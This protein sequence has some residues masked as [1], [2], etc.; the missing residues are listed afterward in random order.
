RYFA[1]CELYGKLLDQVKDVTDRMKESTFEYQDDEHDMDRML[2]GDDSPSIDRS[3][4]GNVAA[5]DD[6]KK[7]GLN[8]ILKKVTDDL[9]KINFDSMTS[10]LKKWVQ[11]S[12]AS[13]TLLRRLLEETGDA[14]KETANLLSLHKFI[15]DEYLSIH[16][17]EAARA[18]ADFHENIDQRL[19]WVCENCG[20]DDSLALMTAND[21]MKDLQKKDVFADVEDDALAA[22]NPDLNKQQKILLA[23]RVTSNRTHK[24]TMIQLH[25]VQEEH[26]RKITLNRSLYDHMMLTALNEGATR[27]EPPKLRNLEQRRRAS[28]HAP[29][30]TLVVCAT[31]FFDEPK[32]EA[33]SEEAEGDS[34]EESGTRPKIKIPER[35]V[36]N[37]QLQPGP[38]TPNQQSR[39]VDLTAARL[40]STA[41]IHFGDIAGL[42]AERNS[43]LDLAMKLVKKSSVPEAVTTPAAASLTEGGKYTKQIRMLRSMTST[44]RATKTPGDSVEYQWLRVKRERLWSD[45]NNVVVEVSIEDIMKDEPPD[46]PLWDTFQFKKVSLKELDSSKLQIQGSASGYGNPL[47]PSGSARPPL[48]PA[49][50]AT[51]VSI[52]F[53][54]VRELPVSLSSGATE[55]CPCWKPFERQVL[56]FQRRMIIDIQPF[57]HSF[58]GKG[59]LDLVS[60]R[61]A[62]AGGSEPPGPA[63]AVSVSVSVS[64]QP[65]GAVLPPAITASAHAALPADSKTKTA[66]ALEEFPKA[67]ASAGVTCSPEAT[68]ADLAQLLLSTGHSAAAVI[69]EGEFKRSISEQDI[70][71]GYLKGTPWDLK[72]GEWLRGLGPEETAVDTGGWRRGQL[73]A[74][75]RLGLPADPVKNFL[76]KEGQE[77]G[78]FAGDATVSQIMEPVNS[79]PVC[80]HCCTVQELLQALLR[81]PGSPAGAALET[82]GRRLLGLCRAADVLWAFC[83]HVDL[84]EKMWKRL[85]V[86]CDL[87]GL[88]C[89]AMAADT[90]LRSAALAMGHASEARAVSD[91]FLPHLLAYQPGGKALVGVLSPQQL[92][93]SSW[94]GTGRSPS[95]LEPHQLEAP[96]AW[97][98]H[99]PTTVGD[100]VAQRQT[101]FCFANESLGEACDDLAK[102]GRTAAIVLGATSG[103]MRGVLTENDILQAFVNG[104]S[105]DRIIDSWLRGDDARLPGFVDRCHFRL[106]SA[107]DIALGLTTSDSAELGGPP[108]VSQAMK[109]RRFV[110]TCTAEDSLADAF[111]ALADSRQNCALVAGAEDFG[112]GEGGEHLLKGPAGVAICGV[113]TVADIVRAV[114]MHK[115]GKCSHT[116]LGCWRLG[117]GMSSCGR[118]IA[119]ESSLAAAAL[120]MAQHGVHHLL[121]V[122]GLSGEVQQQ[123]QQVLG[124]ISALDIVVAMDKWLSERSHLIQ[125]TLALESVVG[126]V[127]TLRRK[128]IVLG[129]PV[130][131][132]FETRPH[133]DTGIRVLRH[134]MVPL[135]D[136]VSQRLDFC[137]VEQLRNGKEAALDQASI[138]CGRSVSCVVC[139]TCSR[140]CHSIPLLGGDSPFVVMG[141]CVEFVH[142]D[143]TYSD[144]SAKD[145]RGQVAAAV[146]VESVASAG[147]E[148]ESRLHLRGSLS[149]GRVF[150]FLLPSRG[151]QGSAELPGSHPEKVVSGSSAEHFVGHRTVD[152]WWVKARLA[153]GSYHLAH[154]EPGSRKVSYTTRTYEELSSGMQLQAGL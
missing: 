1:T 136:M 54:F 104:E 102:S 61:L 150:D 101:P 129:A 142:C 148:T 108:V 154:G 153:D 29:A 42:Y 30:P 40:L 84:G 11:S 111:F 13:D 120:A 105:W 59:L 110:V 100:V 44:L 70:L 6:F 4:R 56:R 97:L 15:V 107:L 125:G 25:D 26:S 5:K 86:R 146:E 151:S 57:S 71:L 130:P 32:Q 109:P 115:A 31:K 47:S 98:Q 17:M 8:H 118:S 126:Q 21:K 18:L 39:Q 20:V 122:G 10:D 87:H 112:A 33:P 138:C 28:I 140:T 133:L 62:P 145:K 149:D 3:K 36:S 65:G 106:L 35:S 19:H 81:S 89:H 96:K 37:A 64:A 14:Q 2:Y 50:Q 74:S 114:S 9:G 80:D 55:R 76:G 103:A 128:S 88:S 63:K 77:E 66:G 141:K 48:S 22:E 92:L 82:D 143:T 79:L 132:N 134:E 127:R 93:S 68:L 34:A 73:D 139:V 51:L 123:Q 83:Q 135:K 72:V 94:E 137:S 38:Q 41:K 45:L 24:R 49:G 53:Y 95:E 69:S 90:P 7:E 60:Q 27:Q 16:L 119:A 147:Q 131:F 116:S 78:N 121:V 144:E 99:H 58:C 43:L 67:R 85:A 117:L 124:V 23:M 46:S 91:S 113:V 75:I 52:R 12:E 152:G